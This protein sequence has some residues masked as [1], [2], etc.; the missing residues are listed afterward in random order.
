MQQEWFETNRRNWDERV[1]IHLHS[2]GLDALRAGRGTLHPI[3]DR[4]FHF[5]P[6]D[7]VLHLQCHFGRDTLTLAQ[8]GA[9]V[10]GIDFSAPAIAAARALTAELGLTEAEFVEANVYEAP[11]V[12]PRAGAF[13]RVFVTW[14]ALNWLPDIEGWAG[15]VRYY[16][17]PGGTLYLAEG[18]PAAYVFDDATR[19]GDG[20]PGW[21]VPYFDP[22]PLG[23]DD[24][25][26]YSDPTARLTNSR[27]YEWIHPLGSI[28]EA[29]RSQGM[30]I[31]FLREHSTV[32]WRMFG[33]LREEAG[34]MFGWPEKRW[35]PLSFSLQATAAGQVRT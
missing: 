33:M 25:S 3:E 23:L 12:Y 21:F 13:D 9:A 11:V 8:R 19:A 34:G 18:H 6:G 31:D 32:P 7:R 26:D 22:Q 5:T 27:T 16:L 14:G 17:K 15:V 2:Y 28:V 4:E 10:T 1:P 20:M 29:L 24:P 30:R 35:L